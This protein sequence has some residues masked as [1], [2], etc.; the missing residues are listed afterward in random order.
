M[1]TVEQQE[2]RL[3]RCAD[4][5]ADAAENLRDNGHADAAAVPQLLADG[6][7]FHRTGA[8]SLVAMEALEQEA[9]DHAINAVAR[10]VRQRIA[11]GDTESPQ[12]L[13]TWLEEVTALY[14]F[15]GDREA[16]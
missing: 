11:D 7:F 14:G 8:A 15:P 9:R 2:V 16:A 3:N 13:V 10:A 1:T 12:P 5:L 4:A 6:E